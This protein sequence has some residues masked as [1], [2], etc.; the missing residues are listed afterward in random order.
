MRYVGLAIV[1]C[2]LALTAFIPGCAKKPAPTSN[3]TS[4]QPEKP[5]P[6]EAKEPPPAPKGGKDEPK[7]P[8]FRDILRDQLGLPIYPGAKQESFSMG[9]DDKGNKVIVASL[10]TPDS[11]E[12]VMAFYRESLMG[13]KESTEKLIKGSRFSGFR[14]SFGKKSEL[15]VIESRPGKPTKIDATVTKPPLE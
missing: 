11:F 1:V 5:P 2:L 8:E 14:R 15:I 10:T 13:Y 4:T 6:V 3:V 7:P 12:K 9:S